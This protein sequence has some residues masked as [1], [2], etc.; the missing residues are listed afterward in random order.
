M[1]E[2]CHLEPPE[3]ADYLELILSGQY[4]FYLCHDL[5]TILE[6]HGA[7]VEQ[8]NLNYH[9]QNITADMPFRVRVL[10]ALSRPVSSKHLSGALNRL[11]PDL[12]VQLNIFKAGELA[13]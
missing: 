4:K 8:I 3:T 11:A 6:S 7:R 10:A 2:K 12:K 13:A 5:R 9:R 1:R